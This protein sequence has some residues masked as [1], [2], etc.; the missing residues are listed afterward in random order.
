VSGLSLC[1]SFLAAAA[2]VVLALHNSSQGSRAPSSHLCS[3]LVH[4]QR[5]RYRALT[6]L[7]SSKGVR[8][9]YKPSIQLRRDFSPGLGRSFLI[10]QLLSCKTSAPLFWTSTCQRPFW[11]RSRTS[12]QHQLLVTMPPKQATLGYVHTSQRNL[13]CTGLLYLR[14]IDLTDHLDL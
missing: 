9:Y 13:G 1:K 6:L 2:V 4:Y 8:D 12:Q 14:N 11:F 5:S 3:T 10:P 7:F